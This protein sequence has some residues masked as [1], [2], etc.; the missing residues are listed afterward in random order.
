MPN[1]K[2]KGRERMAGRPR[3]QFD[4]VAALHAA[5]RDVAER[6]AELTPGMYLEERDTWR[7]NNSRQP[8][9]PLAEAWR[10]AYWGAHRALVSLGEL[11]FLLGPRAGVTW[12]EMGK[13]AGLPDADDPDADDPDPDDSDLDGAG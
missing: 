13:L 11:M 4:A 5:A 6:A 2:R 10:A 9:D 1:G 3:K 12:E 7:R 8:V